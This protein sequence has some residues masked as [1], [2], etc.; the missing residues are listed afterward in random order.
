[1]PM[2]LRRATKTSPT[3]ENKTWAKTKPMT[4]YEIDIDVPDEKMPAVR[5]M[6]L[7]HENL[8]TDE[9]GELKHHRDANCFSN[10]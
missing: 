6:F 3:T 9:L 5:E 4:S 10:G 7:K 1:M 8:W 2:T